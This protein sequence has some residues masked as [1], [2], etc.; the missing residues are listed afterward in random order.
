MTY[1]NNYKSNYS[2]Y[3]GAPFFKLFIVF[4]MGIVLSVF[5]EVY[6]NL[7][8][9]FSAFILV[10]LTYIWANKKRFLIPFFGFFLYV[11]LFVLGSY[12]ANVQKTNTE[13]THFGYTGPMVAR[14]IKSPKVTEWSVRTFIE[15]EAEF[16]D[17]KW[18]RCEGQSLL[19]LQK[20][21]LSKQLKNGDYIHFN[22]NYDAI[23][24]PRNPEVFNY[25]RYLFYHDI[26]QKIN[27]KTGQ[28]KLLNIEKQFWDLSR[29]SDLRSYLLSQYK[30]FGIEGDELAVL[31][32]LTLG[33]KNDLDAEIRKSY[34]SSGAIHVLAV[35]GLHVGV[36]FI[37]INFLLK[38]LGKSVTQRILRLAITLFFIWFFALLTG[39]APSVQRA[40]WM[41]TA[42]SIGVAIKRKGTTENSIFLSAFFIA[43]FQPYIVFDLS[44]QLSYA[45]VLSIVFFQP[46]IFKLLEFKNKIIKYIWG[47]T[48]VSI[49]AQI[50]T[51]PI[52][53][54]Y[55][56]QFPNYFLLSNFIVIPFATVAIWGSMIFYFSLVVGFFSEYIATLLMYLIRV[57][58]FLIE[59]I[60]SIPY[61]LSEDLYLDASQLLFLIALVIVLMQF[62]VRYKL[63]YIF[64]FLFL[65]L[66]FVA[67]YDFRFYKQSM[68]K[69][70][71]IYNTGKDL[72][73]DFIIGKEHYFLSK[74]EEESQTV[75]F[76]IKPFWLSSGLRKAYSFSSLNDSLKNRLDQ[77]NETRLFVLKDNIIQFFN[78]RIVIIDNKDFLNEYTSTKLEID[79]LIITNNIRIEIDKL[80]L[81]FYPKQVIID[82]THY[83]KNIE[84]WLKQKELNPHIRIHIVSREGAFVHNI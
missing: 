42:L 21:S 32:A 44:Y 31:S 29:I 67:Y 16:Q 81:Y 72:S 75:Q 58:N 50:G 34:A 28:W 23:E 24:G 77:N 43:F 48:S 41:L 17:D 8:T 80:E 6:L 10:I 66:A 35:S 47:L 76:N 1:F 11:F 33:Y 37:I 65:I 39:F 73:V 2:M 52:T 55:F 49:A 7:Y 26:A 74:L 27:L 13:R 45:A 3:S 56:N 14:V 15:L 60:E 22:A 51:F 9:L 62:L 61:A 64:T 54:F 59:S 83:K 57:Q 69:K 70:L 82:A 25:K 53:I 18:R 4:A 71:V 30:K 84:F 40:S 46:R 36:V 5:T 79:F 20:D 63:K 12:Q 68:Q 19:I 78:K 38:S